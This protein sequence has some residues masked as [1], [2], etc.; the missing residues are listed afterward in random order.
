[1]HV[2]GVLFK[3]IIHPGAHIPERSDWFGLR[4]RQRAW[5][6]SKLG[7]TCC[8]SGDGPDVALTAVLLNL[9][10]VPT[11]EEEFHAGR[12]L[13]VRYLLIGLQSNGYGALGGDRRR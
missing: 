9:D 3:I 11:C 13:I 12:S 7:L 1:M 2:A 6:D 10:L 4:V 5:R 8:K